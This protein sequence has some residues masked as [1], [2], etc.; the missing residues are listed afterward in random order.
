MKYI[1]FKNKVP[2][3]VVGIIQKCNCSEEKNK[4]KIQL[5]CGHLVCKKSIDNI[6]NDKNSKIYRICC[7]FCDTGT[8]IHDIEAFYYKKNF[9][10]IPKIG[11]E[12]G[13]EE[14]GTVR[15][16]LDEYYDEHQVTLIKY[17]D[18][19]QRFRKLVDDADELRMQNTILQRKNQLL[20]SMKDYKTQVEVLKEDS[21]R[22]VNKI[23]KLKKEN[24]DYYNTIQE[25]YRENEKNKNIIKNQETSISSEFKLKYD[26]QIKNLKSQIKKQSQ[27]TN[28]KQSQKLIELKKQLEQLQTTNTKQ[29][30]EI[31]ILKKQL[32]QSQETY[33]KQ[34]Q[35]FIELKKQSQETNTKQSQEITDLKKQ[36][37]LLDEIMKPKETQEFSTQTEINL[38]IDEKQLN[39][40]HAHY[41]LGINQL[42]N[43]LMS[44]DG[45]IAHLTSVISYLET[46]LIQNNNTTM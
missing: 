20:E 17:A 13:V 36:L 34:S 23:N 40:I 32:E 41:Q 21:I 43:I 7:T 27:K 18:V 2:K 12:I 44:R 19:A 28:T 8:L 16:Q 30:Q 14:D 26:E 24:H 38:N 33:T 1:L 46:K 45:Q 42:N 39:D 25:I 35:E 15:I 10:H 5:P 4:E 31:T 29:T 3:M 6:I 22:M 9:I 37:E 11:M